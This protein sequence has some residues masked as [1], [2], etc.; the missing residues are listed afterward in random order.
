ML[1]LQIKLL[2][3]IFSL[4]TLGYV[5]GYLF[6]L[7]FQSDLV[8]EAVKTSDGLLNVGIAIKRNW[9]IN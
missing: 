5:F 1:N 7:F 8:I 3:L 4:S 9:K 2:Y 6:G